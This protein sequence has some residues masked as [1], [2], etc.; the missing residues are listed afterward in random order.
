[1]EASAILIVAAP[2]IAL[3]VA[4][5]M[6]ILKKHGI[7]PMPDRKRQTSWETFFASSLGRPVAIDCS[8]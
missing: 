8:K 4:I 3:T 7:E 6:G 2:V 5:V 1:V